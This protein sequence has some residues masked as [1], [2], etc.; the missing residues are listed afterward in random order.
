MFNESLSNSLQ[1][2]WI[3]LAREEEVEIILKAL[4][5]L[6]VLNGLPVDRTELEIDCEGE[7]EEDDPPQRHVATLDGPRETSRVDTTGIGN[8]RDT[9][10]PHPDSAKSPFD[11]GFLKD[12]D[13][14][15]QT[16]YSNMHKKRP[17]NE[18]SSKASSRR[19]GNESLGS[20]SY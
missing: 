9:Q 20:Q 4:K 5:G 12:S 14:N 10:Q 3:N 2:L 19:N 11:L 1:E 7:D 15:E 6:K 8:A 17:S 18:G 13:V 16:G